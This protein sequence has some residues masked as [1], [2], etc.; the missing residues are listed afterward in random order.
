MPHDIQI[1]V[2]PHGI[3]SEIHITVSFPEEWGDALIGALKAAAHRDDPEVL[4]LVKRLITMSTTVSQQLDD[5]ATR[6]EAGLAKIS[7]DL[8][9]IATELQATAPAPGTVVTQAQ[10]DRHTAI[11]TAIEAAAAAAGALVV[12]PPPPPAA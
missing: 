8:A 2:A 5:A 10:A 11:A 4:S 1:H 7:A 3:H 12:P 6:D 9:A